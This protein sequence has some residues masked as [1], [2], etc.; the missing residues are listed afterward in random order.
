MKEIGPI[1]GANSWV[2]LRSGAAAAGVGLAS[3]AG[4]VD[5]G[6][7]GLAQVVSFANGSMSATTNGEHICKSL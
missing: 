5:G 6:G 4:S 1:S 3:L 7:D 2:H